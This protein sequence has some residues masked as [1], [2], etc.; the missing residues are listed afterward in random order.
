MINTE[1]VKELIDICN[2]IIEKL[3]EMVLYCPEESAKQI[4]F[5]YRAIRRL[6][7]ALKTKG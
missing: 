2:A 4:N 1:K 5:N 3:K 7:K 6:E